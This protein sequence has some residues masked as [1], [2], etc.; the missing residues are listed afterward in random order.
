MKAVLIIGLS[1][2]SYCLVAQVSN[3]TI[4]DYDFQTIKN[5]ILLNAETKIIPDSLGHCSL[6]KLYN[7]DISGTLELSGN[8]KGWNA[9][10]VTISDR[11][12][13]IYD[14]YLNQEYRK[15]VNG[16]KSSVIILTSSFG[17]KTDTSSFLHFHKNLSK[18][19]SML[20]SNEIK[21]QLVECLTARKLN[22]NFVKKINPSTSLAIVNQSTIEIIPSGNEI[23]PYQ[24]SLYENNRGQVAGFKTLL[25]SEMNSMYFYHLSNLL[26]DLRDEFI[27]KIR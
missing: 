3:N 14:Y 5:Y 6:Y 10:R 7:P 23:P 18:I 24:I 21:T 9:I 26:L 25:N 8:C 20:L 2:A 19:K 27:A 16:K 4:S 13:V 12:D 17:Q 22:S 1:L 11:G 15:E